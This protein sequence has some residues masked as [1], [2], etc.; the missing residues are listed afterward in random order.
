MIEA[1]RHIGTIRM[2]ASGSVRLSNCAAST[3]NTKTTAEHEGEDR[4]VAGADLLVGERRPF[5]GE[6]VGQRF[7]RKLL[8]DLDRLA[9]REAGRRRAIELGGGIDIV[10]RHAIRP[11]DVA[12]GRE[13]AERHG[14]AGRIAHA[15]IEHVLAARYGTAASA[16]ACTRKVRPNRLKSLT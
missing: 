4:G 5:I 1:T 15:Q 8:H 9:L 3:R 12:H 11:G 2:T 14:F 7:R 6:A 13:G 10:A 16:C